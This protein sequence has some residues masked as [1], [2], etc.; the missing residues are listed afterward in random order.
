MNDA[1]DNGGRAT[2]APPA[3]DFDPGFSQGANGEGWG[4]YV[5]PAFIFVFC[6]VVSYICL[7]FD[8]A[9]PLIVG[10]SMQPRVFP[11]FLMAVIAVLNLGL[12]AHVLKT[13][14]SKRDW[15]PPVTWGSA[16]LMA[17]FWALAEYVDM[18]L[19][20][21][22]CMFLLCLL[23]G[24]RRIWV[25]CLVSIGTTAIIFFSFDQILEVRFPRGILTDPYYG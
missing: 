19:G 4:D 3:D 2:D 11:M 10:H 24:E 5:V 12:I 13:P 18:M 6:G 7:T 23:W 16:V 25:A 15:E 20:L 1:A 8:E 17:L 21:I 14:L 9:L 22:V